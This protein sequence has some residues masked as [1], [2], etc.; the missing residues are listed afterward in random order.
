MIV[1]FFTGNLSSA[2]LFQ[3]KNYLTFECDILFECRK[4]RSIFRSLAN[5]ILHKRNYCQDRFHTVNC[6]R[7]DDEV[8]L[9]IISYYQMTCC[10]YFEKYP[11]RWGQNFIENNVIP[12][13]PSQLKYLPSS[14]GEVVL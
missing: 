2:S 12:I 1:F 7:E 14:P 13:K 10:D 6:F 11:L 8:S 5:F 4:C 3:V 9:I